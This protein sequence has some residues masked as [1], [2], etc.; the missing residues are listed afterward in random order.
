[1]NDYK[2][3]MV[4]GDNIY[5]FHVLANSKRDAFDVAWIQAEKIGVD[6]DGMMITL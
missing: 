1:M 4:S 5:D 3:T 2:I 6:V